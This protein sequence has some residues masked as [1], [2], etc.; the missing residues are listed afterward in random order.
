MIKITVFKNIYD[1]DNPTHVDI[2]TVFSLIKTG[3]RGIKQKIKRLRV[4]Q[5][6]L[7]KQ[8]IK[9]DIFVALF[10]GEF[11]ARYDN[12]I[13]KHSGVA[14]LDFDK[15]LDP[16]GFKEKLRKDPYIYA[17]FISPSGTGV[18][19]LVKIPPE[20]ENHGAY[21]LGLLKR[22]PDADPSC[23]NISRACF[24]SYDP[25]IYINNSSK[26]FS[27]KGRVV[28]TK[29]QIPVPSFTQANSNQRLNIA[30]DMIR[31]APDGQK[32]HQLI[33]ASYLVGGFIAGG[34]VE[35]YEAVQSLEMTINQ[36][37]IKDFNNARKAIQDGIKQGKQHPIHADNYQDRYKEIVIQK[38]IV[39]D[40]PVK[41][42]IYLDDVRERMWHSYRHGT[43]RG[44]TTYFP[45][46]DPHFTWRRQEL[47]IWHGIANHGKSAQ[48]YQFCLA[49]SIKEGTKWAVFSPENQPT[50]EFYKDLIHSFIGKSTE[51]HHANQ[52]SEKEFERG[53]DFIKEHFFYIYPKNDS[54][55]PEYIAHRFREL[56][57]KHG[58][59]GCIIDPYNQLDNDMGKD[60][61]EQYLS[62]FLSKQLRFAQENNIYMIII[63]HPKTGLTKKGDNYQMPDNLTLSGGMMWANKADNILCT[64][65]PYYYSDKADPTALFASQKIKKQKLVGIPGIVELYFDYK[66]NRFYQAD[67][68]SPLEEANPVN[69]ETYD[70]GK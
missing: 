14:C 24:L 68:Y 51:R 59:D 52:M 6:E 53:M 43:S 18:K 35:E 12:W 49:K 37:D 60:T 30:L 2:E 29:K 19:A 31:M 17:A 7:I 70:I 62:R 8:R 56:I 28:E 36:R 26:V 50:E 65:R 44:T 48:C 11:S 39:D 40:E 20:I 67:G 22:H 46:I 45:L 5:D 42:V 64:H 34:L 57:I 61:I 13:N 25:E 32:H 38:I 63:A 47:T 9:K 15:L 69:D 54:P 1:K 10:S 16:Y 3:D 58:I 55:T 41:D 66:K 27:E 33:R 4:E 21:Y 23:S